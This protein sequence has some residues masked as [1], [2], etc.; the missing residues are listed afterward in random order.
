MQ[1]RVLGWMT[2]VGWTSAKCREKVKAA[3]RVGSF[4]VVWFAEAVWIAAI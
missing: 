4:V 1:R 2:D 3:V